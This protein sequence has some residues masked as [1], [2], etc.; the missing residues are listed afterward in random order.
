MSQKFAMATGL[1][2]KHSRPRVNALQQFMLYGSLLVFVQIKWRLY[3]VAVSSG[4]GIYVSRMYDLV[5][6]PYSI[7]FSNSATMMFDGVDIILG[8]DQVAVLRS[9]CYTVD[10][11][12]VSE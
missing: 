3:D 7:L 10:G 8:P 12:A 5:H 6:D 2:D 11:L 4:A 9:Q 1:M